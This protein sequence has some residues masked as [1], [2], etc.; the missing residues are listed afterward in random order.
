MDVGGNANFWTN[1]VHNKKTDCKLLNN[2]KVY[3]YAENKRNIS[4][5]WWKQMQLMI[6]AANVDKEFRSTWWVIQK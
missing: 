6:I 3:I 1:S 2:Q 4:Q 5:P